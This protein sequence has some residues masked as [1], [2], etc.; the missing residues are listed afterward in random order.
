M[1]SENNMALLEQKCIDIA[2]AFSENWVAVGKA[3]DKM[4]VD[5]N[6]LEMYNKAEKFGVKPRSEEYE[7]TYNSHGYDFAF[8]WNCNAQN[9]FVLEVCWDA[10]WSYV[11]HADGPS[12]LVLGI[13][14]GYVL[15]DG[16]R[17][18]VR[19]LAETRSQKLIDWKTSHD[20][21]IFED[22]TK[23]AVE[24]TNNLIRLMTDAYNKAL[25]LEHD[26]DNLLLS[27]FELNADGPA[28]VKPKQYDVKIV[29]REKRCASTQS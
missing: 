1:I 28:H 10:K 19:L 7:A 4:L 14:S 3:V 21:S 29:E 13:N 11:S 17:Q 8:V 26:N 15:E 23:G 27:A 5:A 6:V 25:D 24:A 9:K 18:I 20:S 2:K 12:Y 22:F 16:V